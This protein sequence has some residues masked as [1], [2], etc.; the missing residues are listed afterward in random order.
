MKTP[1]IS[2]EQFYVENAS[3]LGLHLLAGA[4][5]LKRIIKEPTVNRP[6]LA[7]AGFTKYF[8]NKRI[9]TIGSAEAT[10]LKSLTKEE[11]LERFEQVC[12]CKIPGWCFLE[13]FVR[14]RSFWLWRTNFRF[15]SS[16]V[17]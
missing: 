4:D 8:A 15:R 12:R 10:Y 3:S 13:T 9:Q 14:T 1:K 7:L 16:A 6:G 11:R 17:R 2:V 5:G